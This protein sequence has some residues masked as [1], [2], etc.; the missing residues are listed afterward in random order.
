MS[1]NKITGDEGELEVIEKIICPNCS[2]KL[3]LLPNSYPLYDV[4]C[5]ACY[6]KAQVKTA[7]SK[8]SDVIFGAGWDIMS[9]VTKSGYPIPPLRVNFKWENKQEVRFYPF[10]TKE[11]LKKRTLSPTA[12]RVNYAM[13]NYVGLNKLP[14]F[15][16]YPK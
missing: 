2:R 3:M 12:R 16:L 7:K 11:N 10:I 14:Y 9:K 4:Q 5:T 13:F 6:F 1:N 8:P 15:K